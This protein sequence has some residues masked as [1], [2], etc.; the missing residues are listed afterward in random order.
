MIRGKTLHFFSYSTISLHYVAHC[1]YYQKVDTLINTFVYFSLERHHFDNF[2]D[3]VVELFE[4]EDKVCIPF[5]IT[6][7][8]ICLTVVFIVVVLSFMYRTHGLTVIEKTESWL[9][10][11]A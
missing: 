4:T 8:C 6:L 11:A 3:Q 5:L 2:A 10:M 1:F 9:F 7:L